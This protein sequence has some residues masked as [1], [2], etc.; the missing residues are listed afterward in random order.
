MT[1]Q[2]PSPY[3][4]AHILRDFA[5]AK[6]DQHPIAAGITTA[7]KLPEY[8]A[9]IRFASLRSGSLRCSLSPI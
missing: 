7:D 9:A 6:A 2:Q 3:Q 8:E 5:Q 4:L 1:N